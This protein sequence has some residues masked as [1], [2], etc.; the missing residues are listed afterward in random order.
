MQFWQ[1]YCQYTVGEHSLLSFLAARQFSN[2][3]LCQDVTFQFS[4]DFQFRFFFHLRSSSLDVLWAFFF[5]FPP[6]IVE[7][8]RWRGRSSGWRERLSN[9]PSEHPS[10]CV[11]KKGWISWKCSR[12]KWEMRGICWF[13]NGAEMVENT[14]QHPVYKNSP[15]LTSYFSSFFFFFTLFTPSL[16][17]LHFFPNFAFFPPFLSM[18]R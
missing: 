4:I 3:T 10:A 15:A 16:H 2:F 12:P 7:S 1:H 11:D 17:S 5:F 13:A 14:Q 6:L 9:Q 18:H 8:E